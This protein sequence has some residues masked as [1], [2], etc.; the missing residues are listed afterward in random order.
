[1]HYVF[2]IDLIGKGANMKSKPMRVLVTAPLGVGGI[3]SLMI[4]IQ[5]NMDRDVLNF[6]Y[7]TLHD[8]KE[9]QE[10]IVLEMGS[11]KY[12]ASA[13]N[14]KIKPLRFVIR[15]FQIKKICKENNVKVFHNNDG[16]PKGVLNA[17]AAKAGGVKY[18]TYH[19]H[20]GG[21]TDMSGFSKIVNLLCRPLIPLVCDDLW[22]CSTLAA[23]FTFPSYIVKNK[24]FHFMP[25]AIDLE[26]YR[27]DSEAREKTRKELGLVGKFVIGHAG[28]FNK[29]KNH[30]FLIEVFE[31][32]YKK[33]K[34]AI[35]VLFG[36][37]ETQNNIRDMVDRLGLK[38]NV[39][40]FGASNQMNK[41]YNAMDVFLMPSIFE[42][43]PVTGIEA[44]AA[45]L[46]IVFSDVITREV[47]IAPNIEYIS[48]KEKKEIWADKVLSFKGQ[49]RR[50]YC[51]ELKKA[52]F[53]QAEMVRNFQDYYL[54]VG[55]KLNLI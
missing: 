30:E 43:L 4:N 23:E 20:N 16:T 39:I 54:K 26:R 11:N 1:M 19:S 51:E 50:D 33:D 49:E 24:K 42:G 17:I 37:G 55:S 47:A 31:Q 38:D 44:Q 52:G 8:R 14:V 2:K 40:F 10:D 48:L 7:L 27:F 53:E 35:L 45:G 15:L 46:P 41:M 36:V 12:V 29:Q 3:S 21:T 9:P 25:N 28:R 34:D 32:V 13:D 22:A 6:D 5:K 18:I